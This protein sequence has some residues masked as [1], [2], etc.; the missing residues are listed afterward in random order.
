MCLENFLLGF[1]FV[2]SGNQGNTISLLFHKHKH[3][4]EFAFS[5]SMLCCFCVCVCVT[6][7]FCVASFYKNLSFVFLFFLLCGVATYVESFKWL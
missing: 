5:F 7:M 1:F 2:Y 3:Q 4:R 6:C